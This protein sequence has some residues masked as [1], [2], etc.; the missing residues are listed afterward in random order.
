MIS[1][2]QSSVT[3]LF[4]TLGRWPC[5]FAA[6]LGCV[7]HWLQLMDVVRVDARN[8]PN[9]RLSRVPCLRFSFPLEQW[10]NPF[11]HLPLAAVYSSNDLLLPI[12]ASAV[13]ISLCALCFSVK[14]VSLPVVFVVSKGILIYLH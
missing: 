1:E 6:A 11:L 10:A 13:W 8:H 3:A 14:F 5:P 4:L 9:S 12:M 7:G 2:L